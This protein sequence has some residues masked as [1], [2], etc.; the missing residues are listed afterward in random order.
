[1]SR[2]KKI[3][4][5]SGLAAVFLSVQSAQTQVIYTDIEPDFVLDTPGYY[6]GIDL[7]GNGIEDFNFFNTIFTGYNYVFNRATVKKIIWVG[8][9]DN[10]NNAIA[11]RYTDF[12]GEG[13][14]TFYPFAIAENYIISENLSSVITE[15]ADVYKGFY[16]WGYQRMAADEYLTLGAGDEIWAEGPYWDTGVYDHYLGI[17][18]VDALDQAHY[19][20]IR[21]DVYEDERTVVIKDYAYELQPDLPIVAGSV[22]SYLPVQENENNSVISVYSFNNTININ[23]SESF[24]NEILISVFDATGKEL[25]KTNSNQQHTEV[26]MHVPEGIYIVEVTSEKNK[27]VKKVYL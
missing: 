26:F 6:Y 15:Y 22:E 11:A 8:G 3:T 12:W 23:T 20:W 25:T 13:V 5:Y 24:G 19:G 9:W 4:A 18:F 2:Y 10:E 17:R 21:C 27:F 16:N 14:P 1:M 7:N